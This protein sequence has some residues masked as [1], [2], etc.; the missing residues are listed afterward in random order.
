MHVWENGATSHAANQ[1]GA[2]TVSVMPD[3]DPVSSDVGRC[4]IKGV[5]QPKDLG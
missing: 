1:D 3:L 2:S 4:R 5:F